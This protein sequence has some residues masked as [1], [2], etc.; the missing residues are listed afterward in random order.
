VVVA[1]LTHIQAALVE[2][3]QVKAF[4]VAIHQEAPHTV[5]VAAVAQVVQAE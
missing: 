5:V 2:E 3:Y 4:R 1:R